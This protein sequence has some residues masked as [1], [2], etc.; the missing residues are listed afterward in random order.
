MDA[1]SESS[2]TMTDSRPELHHEVRHEPRHEAVAKG[3]DAVIVSAYGRGNWLAQELARR[4]W[5]VT[6]TDVT[7]ALG[8]HNSEEAEGPFGFFETSDLMPTQKSCL[9]AEGGVLSATGGFTFW[10]KGGPLECRSGLTAFALEQN[11]VVKALE[12]YLR[13]SGLPDKESDRRRRALE[14]EPFR[15]TWLAHFAHQLASPVHDENHRALAAGEAMPLFAPF[16]IRQASTKIWDDGLKAVRASGV[17]VR[18]NATVLD[19]RM[20]DRAVDAIEIKDDHAGIERGRTFI[21][22]LSSAESA[23]LPKVVF[24]TLYPGGVAEPSWFWACYHVTMTAED[25]D[26]SLPIHTVLIEDPFLP[27]THAN[28]IVLR[29]RAQTKAYAAWVK[30]PMQSRESS[31]EMR[32]IGERIESVLAARIPKLAPKVI[33]FSNDPTARPCFPIFDRDVLEDLETLQSPN[34][35][36]CGPEQC[37]SLDWT[38]LYR[39][40][41]QV[42][43]RLEKMRAHWIAVEEKEL[44]RLNRRKS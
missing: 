8:V 22:M 26:D 38:G 36:Y 32:A 34:L 17:T 14:R 25:P 9:L 40:Q 41:N 11:G 37:G 5:S 28:V 43:A 27:W 4:G 7:S 2:A 42:L 33:G 1:G 19:L 10:L 15:E 21:W 31:D 29:K 12:E 18:S 30:L 35:F 20:N 24:E 13:H 23:S 44:A 3:A 16:W 6:L 39:R